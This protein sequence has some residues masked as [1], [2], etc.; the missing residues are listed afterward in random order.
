MAEAAHPYQPPEDIWEVNVALDPGEPLDG[1]K[2]PRWVDTTHA[3]GEYNLD[4]FLRQ[5]GVDGDVLKSPPRSGYYLFCGHRGCGKSTELRRIRNQLHRHGAYYVVFADVAEELDVSNLRY[6]DVLLHLAGTLLRQLQADAV[7]V[8]PEHLRRLQDWFVERVERHDKTRDFA[9]EAKAGMEAQ[10][11]LPFMAKLFARV[12]DTFKYNSTYKAE[13]RLVL[14]NHF[15]DFAEAFNDLI[16]AGEDALS[17]AAPSDGS[18]YQ[19]IL[20]VVDGT[21]RLQGEDAKALFLSDVYQLQ[22]VRGLFV[23]CAPVHLTY[24]AALGQNFGDVFRLPMIKVANRDG[25]PNEAGVAAMRAI[26]VRRAASTLFDEGVADKLVRFSGGHPRDLLRLLQY[27]FKHSRRTADRFEL[28]AAEKA[29][30]ELAMDFLRILDAE[31]Y[32]L[33]REVDETMQP[34]A[35]GPRTRALLYNLAVLEYNNLFWRSHPVIRT[36]HAYADPGTER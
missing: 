33:L 2:D 24:E 15:S 14:R 16:G 8:A 28:D 18:P 27:T 31:D 3:R 9:I 1:E 11:G 25:S 35:P 10:L 5:L 20:F 29:I 13:L 19:R 26:L 32:P 22:Q 21:D 23:Y 7:H 12:S 36:L 30:Q 6:P 4:A 34:L 17:R